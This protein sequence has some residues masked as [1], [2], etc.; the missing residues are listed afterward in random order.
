MVVVTGVDGSAASIEAAR[1]AACEAAWRGVPL[2]IVHAFARPVAPIKLGPGD[3]GPLDDL[4]DSAEQLLAEAERTAL[5]E[6]PGLRVVTELREGSPVPVLIE[7]ARDSE[8][9]VLGGRGL[10]G[11]TGLLL[12]SVAGQAAAYAPVPVLVCKGF[13][14][15]EGPVVAGLDGSPPTPAMLEQAHAEA[16][17]RDTDLL[18]VTCVPRPEAAVE[19]AEQEQVSAKTLAAMGMR[20]PRVR[21]RAELIRDA[22]ARALIN[23]SEGAQLVVVGARGH[24]GFAGLLLGSVSQQLL[25]HAHCPVLVV[26]A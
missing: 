19:S 9:L 20:Y 24:G 13:A 8:L 5:Q 3:S 7:A 14:A 11:F 22:P 16:G 1:Q 2:T 10:G 4:R 18:A 23:L 25:H 15:D 12:G 17:W 6:R 26:R 21:V